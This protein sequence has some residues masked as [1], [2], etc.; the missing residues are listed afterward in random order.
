[1]PI[2]A[3]PESGGEGRERDEALV[4]STDD[5]EANR[6]VSIGASYDPSVLQGMSR[7][8][9]ARALSDPSSPTAQ[10]VL[11]AGNTLTAAIGQA[12]GGKPALVSAGMVFVMWSSARSCS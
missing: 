9:I 12:T 4:A 1:V 11:G 8:A 6:Y 3:P 10:V 5:G 2:V 7:E